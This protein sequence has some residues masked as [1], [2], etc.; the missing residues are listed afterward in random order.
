MKKN[1]VSKY[2]VTV[3]SIIVFVIAVVVVS[4][5]TK[6]TYA[7]S[8]S[9]YECS[10][11]YYEYIESSYERGPQYLEPYGYVC[12]LSN[13]KKGY[14]SE[15]FSE[16]D[17]LTEDASVPKEDTN[18]YK[19]LKE[20]GQTYV[21]HSIGGCFYSATKK[22]ENKCY[23]CGNSQGQKYIW[24]SEETYGS[25]SNCSVQNQY[26]NQ[27]TCEGNNYIEYTVIYNANGGTGTTASS[28][29]KYGASK[30]LTANGFSREGY[31][32]KGWATTAD[33]V[34][35]YADKE[36]VRDLSSTNGA[37]INLYAI[38]NA[39]SYTVSYNANGG[40]GTTA[41]STHKYGVPKALTANGFSKED[42]TFAGWAITADGPVK[43]T[44]KE[45]VTNLTTT[46]GE[47]VTLYAIWKVNSSSGSENDEPTVTYIVKYDANGGIGTTADS[48]HTYGIEKSL[49]ANGFSNIGY[50]FMGWS[51]EKNE[52][53]SFNDK[54]SVSNLT[55]TNG[56]I[57]TLYAVWKANSYKI[58]YE[59]VIVTG[60]PT[61]G[62]YNEVVT[63]DNPTKSVK[64]YFNDNKTDAKIEVE[65][66]E[67]KL[68]FSG[69]TAKDIDTKIATY[70]DKNT[71]WYDAANKVLDTKFKNLTSINDKTV[72]LVANWDKGTVTLPSVTKDGHTCLWNTKE[73][74]KGDN[75]NS[76]DKFTISGNSSTVNLYAICDKYEKTDDEISSNNKTGDTLIK[77]VWIIGIGALGYSVYYFMKRRSYM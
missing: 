6:K 56:G 69:W 53:V 16:G 67:S 28:T 35:K 12:M 43:Y 63:I 9:D 60:F 72:T 44:D 21:T 55:S 29:H 71:L 5:N 20:K 61:S 34:V 10:L 2:T 62:T 51:K 17:F 59:N 22:N 36:S 64:V 14:E 49:T 40:T 54:Q 45:N 18:C 75:Y 39:N 41:S 7:E 38:W 19:Y 11:G 37:T 47:T 58:T 46:N 57:V 77:T 30:E 4:I 70:G 52:T 1:N 74:G 8:S 50:T 13:V 26:S 32:F 15:N 73:D 48:L 31:I 33:G 27:S 76:S 66:L 25:A 23:V 65:S 24:G 68:K 42:H 3:I